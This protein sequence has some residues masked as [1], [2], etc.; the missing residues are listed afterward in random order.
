M[1]GVKTPAERGTTGAWAYQARDESGLS[2]EQ[3]IDQLQ[4]RGT[5]V[6]ASTIRGVEGG[7]KKPGRRLLRE[8]AAVYGSAPP[9]AAEEPDEDLL[10]VISRQAA[11][12][13][14]L[15]AAIE[16]DRRS[17]AAWEKGLLEAF[18]ELAKSGMQ[19][20]GPAPRTLADTPR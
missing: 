13:D 1:P 11:A 4:A 2:V 20:G 19:S 12:I 16:A 15:A 7:S 6:T 18:R 17:R 10:A 8:L 9:G 3:V 5:T 14:A